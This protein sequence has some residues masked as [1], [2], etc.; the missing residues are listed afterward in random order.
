MRKNLKIV[1]VAMIL[2][3]AFA[4]SAFAADIA[5]QGNYEFIGCWAG[6]ATVIQFS[7]TNFGMTLEHTGTILSSPSGSIF[8]HMTFH[9]V[10]SQLSFGG[11]VYSES[12]C[13]TIDRDGDKTFNHYWTSSDGKLNHEL[14]AGT[15]KYEGIEFTSSAQVLGQFPTVKPGAYQG[16]ARETG[17]YKL[18]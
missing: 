2:A 15:G 9:C 13:E 5:K 4:G 3:S 1:P 6:E 18:K 7:N 16:C 11:K 14:L 17:T 12:A 8:D 10:G